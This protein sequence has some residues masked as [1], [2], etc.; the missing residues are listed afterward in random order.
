MTIRENE[1]KIWKDLQNKV[2]EILTVC[3]YQC[4]IEKEIITLTEKV[5]IDVYAETNSQV[6]KSVIICE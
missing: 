1:P 4:E 5:N 2:A 3:G 6:S